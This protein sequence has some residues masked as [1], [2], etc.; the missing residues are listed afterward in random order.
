MDQQGLSQPQSPSTMD[1][2]GTSES[3]SVPPPPL[4]HLAHAVVSVFER[5]ESTNHEPKITVNR[6]L[7]E[8]ASWYEKLRNAM[9][10]RDDEVVLK[11]AI[12]RILK[13]RLLLGGN[14][15]RV[16][17]PLLRELIWAHYFPNN[18]IPESM[19]GRVS[20]A[21]DMYLA[22][23]Y[24][25]IEEGM[26]EKDL[27][28]W[29]FQVLSC[30]LARLLSPNVEKN[31]MSNFMYHIMKDSIQIQDDSEDTKNVQVYLAVRRA[32][33]KDDIAFL[34]YYLFQQIFGE[35][36]PENLPH[37]ERAF[38]KGYEEIERQLRYPLKEKIYLFV[39][40]LTPVFFILEDILRKEKEKSRKLLHNPEEFQK[41][42]FAACKLRYKGI[43]SKVT[44]AI[45]R[46]V[47]FLIITKAVIAFGVEGT[48][49]RWRYGH[50]MYTTIALNTGIPPLLMII[51]SLFIRTPGDDNSQ[52]ILDKINQ[53]LYEDHPQITPNKILMLN[54]PKTRS[55]LT[56]VFGALG[57]AAFVVSFGLIIYILTQLHF[58]IVS[59]GIFIFFITIVSFL[60]YRINLTA[61]EYTVEAKQGLLTPFI[62]FL[63]I[64]IVRVGMRLTEGISQVNIIIFLFDF[65]IEA[66]FK[67]VFGFF[68]QFFSYLHS[69]RE[70]LG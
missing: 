64:P 44:R 59:Q 19:T 40:R 36:T 38:I 16:A 24:A 57:L 4:S 22:L 11:S 6:F 34:R 52:R 5:K 32:F 56:V 63:I 17:E 45:V 48:Y 43:R 12:E 67:A 41:E 54:P 62:D 31:T 37:V 46:S 27:N 10:I 25:A 68:E 9:D 20:Q 14:G 18:T 60:A 29:T 7:S 66:P 3:A 8:I 51:V 23:R 70:E 28:E 58:N 69:G 61:H 39:K 13:R 55:T 30:H 15:A 2:Q 53:V 42:V 21:V 1:T 26:P 47:I 50:I 65:L 49:E 33:A 35:L